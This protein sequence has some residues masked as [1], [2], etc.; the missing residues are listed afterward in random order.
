MDR[1]WILACLCGP[2]DPSRQVGN[3]GPPML[4]YARLRT[5]MGELEARGAASGLPSF[6]GY[7]T[8]IY[9]SDEEQRRLRER[10]DRGE[11]E[12]LTVRPALDSSHSRWEAFD[13]SPN[14]SHVAE[15]GQLWKSMGFRWG[16]DF[17]T[18]DPGHFDLG[19][20]Q[21]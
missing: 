12:G 11:R 18:P 8:S 14:F 17:L 7:V 6:T 4:A 21:D 15:Y 19:R 20:G 5:A 2:T 1:E 16:G 3:N 13:I 9:R 10:W